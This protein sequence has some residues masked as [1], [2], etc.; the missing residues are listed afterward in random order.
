MAKVEFRHVVKR[1]GD[2][3]VIPD[4]NLTIEDGEFVALLGPSGCGK[5]T[6]PLHAGRHLSAERRRDLVRRH[7]SSTRLR[8]K[9][10][11]V[12]IV[13]QSYALYPH[14]TVRDNV[15]F[16]LALQANAA[17]R[18]ARPRRARRRNLVQVDRASRPAAGRAVGRP[19]AAGG[20]RPRTGQGAAAAAPRRAAFQ[21][22]RDTA[23]DDADRDQVTAAKSSG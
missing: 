3:E 6:T 17:R 18:G 13:F 12:G 10:R 9:D 1:F 11:N 14:M 20:A 16:P 2:V 4:L 23:A 22:R 19:A 21:S 5:S 15:L 7:A 8:R